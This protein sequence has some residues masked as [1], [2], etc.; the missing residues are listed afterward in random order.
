MKNRSSPLIILLVLLSVAL[1]LIGVKLGKTIERVDKTYISPTIISSLEKI[2]TAP[3]KLNLSTFISADCGV[4][5]LYPAS[6]ERKDIS[7]EEAHLQ[8]DG[9]SINLTCEKTTIS[10]FKTN[11]KD[12]KPDQ[13]LQLNNQKISIFDKDDGTKEWTVYNTQNAK[14][15]LFESSGNLTSLILK[16]V[17]FVK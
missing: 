14:T 6:L 7:S 4:T 17:E 11:T 8:G 5:F 16:T 10:Q 13:T 2:S 9:Q 12:K 3:V 15:L 1:F